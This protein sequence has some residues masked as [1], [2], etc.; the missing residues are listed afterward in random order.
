MN[1]LDKK[2]NNIFEEWPLLKHPY[3]YKLIKYNFDQIKLTNFCLTQ[4]KWNAFFFTIQQNTQITNCKLVIT[5]QLLSYLIPSKQKIKQKSIMA[6][7]HCHKASIA[8]SKNCMIKCV[9]TSGDITKIRQEASDKARE[10][11]ISV[12]FYIIIVGTI[13]NVSNS[14]V[15]IDDVLYSTESVLKALDVCFKAFHVLKISYPDASNHLWTFIQ[16]RLYKF[17]IQWD[18]SFSNTTHVL[19][20]L[21]TN[22]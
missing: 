22:P 11:Q 10:M 1:L 5:I 6:K 16:K 9:P 2:L 21:T 18:T 3:G 8:L 20:Q 7:N 17:C 19:K 15:T 13:R 14:C 4:E 12:Q